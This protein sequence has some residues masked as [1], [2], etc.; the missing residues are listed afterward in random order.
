MQFQF[1]KFIQE[2][3]TAAIYTLQTH[4]SSSLVGRK[5]FWFCFWISRK[6]HQSNHSHTFSVSEFVFYSFSVRL[7]RRSM[8][9]KVNSQI[10]MDF[11]FSNQEF[12]LHRAF[13]LLILFFSFL[14]TNI[15]VE[16]P[17]IEEKKI[18]EFG[19]IQ[20]KYCNQLQNYCVVNVIRNMYQRSPFLLVSVVL[21]I[22]TVSNN[23]LEVFHCILLVLVFDFSFILMLMIRRFLRLYFAPNVLHN[24]RT[25]G[26]WSPFYKI[27]GCEME[28]LLEY[29][30][31]QF[32]TA[33]LIFF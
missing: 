14:F 9:S 25:I 20:Q 21:H 30:V 16:W 32:R 23:Y 12:W 24:W 5:S 7:S 2:T 8:L 6:W 26:N 28:F 13:I 31:W 22:Y 18:S 15:S 11:N 1:Y 3:K 4:T 17:N 29:C 10:Q 27:Y 33:I 19:T